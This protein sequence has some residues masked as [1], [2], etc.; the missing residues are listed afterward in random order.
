VSAGL[1]VRSEPLGSWRMRAPS[2]HG[3]VSGPPRMGVVA[4]RAK[5]AR[6]QEA[7]AARMSGPDQGRLS[8]ASSRPPSLQSSFGAARTAHG[9]VRAAGVH[10]SGEN[11]APGA[12]RSGILSSRQT[13]ASRHRVANA[14]ASGSRT[15]TDG[16]NSGDVV[17]VPWATNWASGGSSATVDQAAERVVHHGG[18]V[19]DA[20]DARRGVAVF[21]SIRSSAGWRRRPLRDWFAR[22]HR[23]CR[24][25]ARSWCRPGR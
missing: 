19:P 4:G 6:R 17:L 9:S 18:G 7:S 1:D 2:S 23:A 24:R 21:V 11:V 25:T 16:M 14:M 12:E 13:P 10:P 22:A 3:A 20:T 15:L 8:R 5:I